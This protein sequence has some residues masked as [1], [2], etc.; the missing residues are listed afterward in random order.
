MKT[1]QE[2]VLDRK[3][4]KEKKSTSQEQKKLF[5]GLAKNINSQNFDDELFMAFAKLFLELIN[6][7][8]DIEIKSPDI[9][10]EVPKI[11]PPKIPEIVVPKTEVEVKIPPIKSP[12]IEIPEIIINTGPIVD[13]IKSGFTNLSIPTVKSEIQ[14]ETMLETDDEYDKQGNLIKMTDIYKNGKVIHTR[15]P[16]GGWRVDDRRN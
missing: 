16:S 12:K 3:L 5:S 10:V 1:I 13:A 8:N 15:K 6:S 2:I 11:D 14:N 7:I 9:K 4:N